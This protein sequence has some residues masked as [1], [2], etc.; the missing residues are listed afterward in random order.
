[1]EP[2]AARKS[3]CFKREVEGA[4]QGQISDRKIVGEQKVSEL[5]LSGLTAS[6][7]TASL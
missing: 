6:N 3:V 2:E 1:M 5:K 7:L 4:L